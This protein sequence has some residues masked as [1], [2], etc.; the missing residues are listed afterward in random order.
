MVHP[1]V[2]A[3]IMVH[4][5]KGAIM[6]PVARGAIM[7]LPRKAVRGLIPT[8]RI[9]GR[10]RPSIRVVPA[11]IA[12]RVVLV[13]PG[14]PVPV[15]GVPAA[16]PVRGL[17]LVNVPVLARVLVVL[18]V[19]AAPVVPAAPAVGRARPRRPWL[20]AKAR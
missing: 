4:P 6:V 8:G 17:R 12:A 11:G 13:A 14:D 19:P 15:T 5:A 2:P 3:V 9:R 10:G 1:A 16:R 7:A 18:A 20:K